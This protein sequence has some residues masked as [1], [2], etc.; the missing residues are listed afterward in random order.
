MSGLAFPKPERG[1]L[2]RERESQR[3]AERAAELKAKQLAKARDGHKCRWPHKCER[4][5]PIESAHLVDKSLGGTNTTDNLITL[6][7]RVHRGAVSIHSKLLKVEPLTER[8]AN[9][10]CAFYQLGESGN[11]EHVAT[12]KAVGVSE[13]R[14]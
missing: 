9:G 14:R 8:G 12:E 10:P 4:I 11:W 1:S 6:C 3:A 13:V 7:Q 2:R 5:D